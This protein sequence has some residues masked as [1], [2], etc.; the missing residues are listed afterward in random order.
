MGNLNI[1]SSVGAD[2][3]V[4]I[5]Y[6]GIRNKQLMEQLISMGYDAKD[7]SVTKSTD[8][9]LVPYEGFTSSKTSK[10]GENT[11]IIP[12]DYFIENMDNILAIL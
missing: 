11:M 1:V 6:S 9:L 2:K 3:K 8:I 5:R 4:C 7:S 10:A 12:V